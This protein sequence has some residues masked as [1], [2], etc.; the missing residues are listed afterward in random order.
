[1]KSC[2]C[3]L[4]STIDKR[5]D[6]FCPKAAKLTI[7][8]KKKLH[9]VNNSALDWTEGLYLL[10]INVLASELVQLWEREWWLMCCTSDLGD[11]KGV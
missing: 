4:L 11:S 2:I 9:M 3:Y 5:M 6:K 1:M 8:E 7:K 10:R